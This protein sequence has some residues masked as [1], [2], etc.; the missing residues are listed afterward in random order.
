[1]KN[2]S[3]KIVHTVNFVIS[4][5]RRGY[6][7]HRLKLSAVQKSK[8]HCGANNTH[9]SWYFQLLI[10][11]TDKSFA[12]QWFFDFWTAFRHQV[13]SDVSILPSSKVRTEGRLFMFTVH[14]YGGCAGKT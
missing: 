11:V 9:F 8:N 1:M 10:T 14:V 12:P 7:I 2:K 13:L 6:V 3:V 4:I 5:S